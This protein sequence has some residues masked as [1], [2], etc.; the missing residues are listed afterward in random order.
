MIMSFKK[1]K[2]KF[3][4]KIKL[5]H[6][7]YIQTTDT[8]MKRKFYKHFGLNERTSRICQ[9]KVLTLYHAFDLLS[10]SSGEIICIS[11]PE[12]SQMCKFEHNKKAPFFYIGS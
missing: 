4:P 7:I 8:A 11:L 12:C 3:E 6:N 1:R 2:I 5:N 10:I 9:Q